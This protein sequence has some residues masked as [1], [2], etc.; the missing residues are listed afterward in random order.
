MQNDRETNV[1]GAG[2]GG[3][4]STG[5]GGYGAQPTGTDQTEHSGSIAIDT[6]ARPV[7]TPSHDHSHGAAGTRVKEMAADVRHRAAEQVQSKIDDQKYRAADSL[8]NVAQSLR[9]ASEHMSG[10]ES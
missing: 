1:T 2:M 9:T 6:T 10:N 7:N 5:T 8:G 4:Q 3:G